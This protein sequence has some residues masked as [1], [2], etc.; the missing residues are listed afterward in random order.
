MR[1]A[2]E[3]MV[4]GKRIIVTGGAG[5]L[6]SALCEQLLAEGHLVN[7][8]D[9]FLTGRFSNVRH[10]I[11]RQSFKL[12]R[13]DVCAP[14]RFDGDVDEIYNLACPASPPR[15]Q[16]DPIYTMKINVVGTLNMLD[17]AQSKRAKIL[18]ASTSEVYGDPVVHPQQESYFGNV[19]MFGARACYDEGKRCAETLFHDY[20]HERGIN[21]RVARIF[22]TYGPGMS[23]DDGR[24]ISNFI[25]QA[26]RSDDITIY[27]TG[28]QTR[29]FCY[30]DDLID[31][32]LRLMNADDSL[33]AP[34]NLGNPTEIAVRTLADRIVKLTGSRST[35]RFLP[36]PQD[37]P[38]QRCPEISKAR[39]LLGWEPKVPLDDGLRKTIAYFADEIHGGAAAAGA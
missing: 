26:L 12:I 30:R 17:F 31:G 5:F 37:D 39:S 3:N 18:Q 15:Y 13:H 38:A 4:G 28:A 11:G 25:V 16:E 33:R 24:V 8:V 35:L 21:V 7:C 27:G 6:G 20:A 22:N 34:I 2:G 32:L 14:L 36:R 23:C 9:N 1:F 10:L 29:S 19:N